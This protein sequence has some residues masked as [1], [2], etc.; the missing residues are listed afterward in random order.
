MIKREVEMSISLT[1]EELASEFLDMSDKEQAIFFNEIAK[2]I[3]KWD[4][5]FFSTQLEWVR[6]NQCLTT[7]GRNIMKKIGEYSDF[8]D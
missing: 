4:G 3:S 6:Q 2:L 5:G 8:H 1:P 7:E